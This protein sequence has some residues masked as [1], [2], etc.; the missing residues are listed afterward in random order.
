M[1][2]NAS[3]GYAKRAELLLGANAAAG[4]EVYEYTPDPGSV[5]A[6]ASSTQDAYDR[7]KP[8]RFVP[9]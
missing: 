3:S 5:I 7:G 4:K 2:E 8:R 6:H 9:G 1:N